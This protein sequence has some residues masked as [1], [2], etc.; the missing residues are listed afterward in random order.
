MKN[1]DGVIIQEGNPL[2]LDGV[3]VSNC[4]FCYDE[5][6]V[7]VLMYEEVPIL[8]CTNCAVEIMDCKPEL[9]KLKKEKCRKRR[10]PLPLGDE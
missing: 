8:L 5:T 1:R 7:H 4:D 9:D 10:E 3:V 2:E 6:S